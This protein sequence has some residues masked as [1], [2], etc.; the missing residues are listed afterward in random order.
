ML[1]LAFFFVVLRPF[2]KWSASTDIKA[3]VKAL[4]KTIAEL[5]AD[6]SGKG[7]LSLTEATMPSIGEVETLEK[8]EESELKEKIMARLEGA[9][10]KASRIVLD[11][12]EEGTATRLVKS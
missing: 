7:T 12:I 2:L 11:W 4:P 10:K 6:A 8:K 3:E 9:P 5:E 1:I